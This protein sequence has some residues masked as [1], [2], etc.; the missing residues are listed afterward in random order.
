[1]D[2]TSRG[3]HQCERVPVKL[4]VLVAPMIP[5]PGEAPPTCSVRVAGVSK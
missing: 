5:A 3:S 2:E 4:V 1:M